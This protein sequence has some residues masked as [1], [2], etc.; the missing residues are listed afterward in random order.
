M[1]L[2]KPYFL[3]HLA[4]ALLLPIVLLLPASA[5]AVDRT[6]IGPSGGD[7]NTASNWSGGVVPG[8]GD[9]AIISG[10][11]VTVNASPAQ[12][13]DSVQIG[14]SNL[15]VAAGATLNVANS[16]TLTSNVNF[17]GPGAI[18]FA[19]GA[20]LSISAG[21]V[22][23]LAGADFTLPAGPG[24]STS[25]SSG[26]INM[27]GDAAITSIV[28]PSGATFPLLDGGTIAS[29]TTGD[30]ARVVNDG[31][32][33]KSGAGTTVLN[34]RFRNTGTVSVAAGTLNV[35]SGPPD[36][37]SH[38]AGFTAAAGAELRL[39]GG[40]HHLGSGA[41][42][43]GQGT[44]T[45]AGG[46]IEAGA[47]IPVERMRFGGAIAFGAGSSISVA[48]SLALVGGANAQ[49]N[50]QGAVGFAAG[51]TLSTEPGFGQL[52]LLGGVDFTL[53][54]GNGTSWTAGSIQLAGHAEITSLVVPAGATFALLDGGFIGSNTT[55]DTARIVNNG[56]VVKSGAG[57]TVVNPQFF[58]SGLVDVQAGTMG[59][60][61][62][63]PPFT[64]TSGETDV[65]SGAFLEMNATLDGGTLR[66]RGGV[67]HVTNDGGT[68][69]PG[70]AG[71]IGVLSV[72]GNYT[73]GSGGTLEVDI[74]GNTVGNGGATGYDRLAVGA[75]AN[76]AGTLA[77]VNNPS[78]APQQSD[79][80]TI[81]TRASGSGT[82][83]T[84]TG[85]VTSSGTYGATYTPTEVNLSLISEPPTVTINQAAGQADPTSSSP[86]LFDVVFSEPVT[87]FT[88]SDVSFAGSTVGGSLAAS[89]SGSGA[90]YTVSVTGMSGSGTVVASI[91]AGAA[92]DSAGN[93]SSASTSTDNSVTFVPD[94]AP[95]VTINQASG[96]ADPTS[97]SPILFDV[98]FSEP[99][100]GFTGGDVSFAGSTVGGSLTAS[101]SGSGASYQ[102][103]VSGM[104]SSGDVV[105][106]IPAG[107][108]SDAGGNGN[109][110]STSTDNRV[111]FV[112]QPPPSG[113]SCN[114]VAATI[115]V[116]A[117]GRIVGGPDNGKPYRGKLNGTPAADVMAG[118]AGRDEFAARGGNDRLCGREGNDEL[119]G[120]G[121]HDTL[122]G[123]GGND[124]LDAGGGNDTLTGGL[125]ADKFMGGTGRDTATDFTPAQGDTKT[126]VE[127]WV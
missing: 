85:A 32:I 117:D 77:I 26:V 103:S 66:G 100:T 60:S 5:Y 21:N 57:K 52:Q 40:A 102:V 8:P 87:G 30:T 115:Y 2:R 81:L 105:A 125:G 88:G 107:A 108:A 20:A 69:A 95:S 44:V 82:F 123:E 22:G 41:S 55:A 59:G 43:A 68:V 24:S 96:Q 56:T 114:G 3:M 73:Q 38:T 99:V 34:P 65:A 92:T 63:P 36:G 33:T 111:A 39:L 91:P 17:F 47:A 31:T 9:T 37:Q 76:L 11:D 97:S 58:N 46:A 42:F 110:A 94:A 7:W 64:Q 4:I 48:N 101:V 126:G 10:K 84:L 74:N 62:G 93:P 116:G 120:G 50:G 104:T 79:V 118:T 78:F 80:F 67:S 49:F 54:P 90:N 70:A 15:T 122:F 106:S 61:A 53:P 112:Q 29:N 83:D 19:S 89:V 16:M 14:G 113:P 1:N 51:A 6:F 13:P 75:A 18:D 23:F 45:Y 127:V 121:G 71:E 35:G 124:E 12:S 109:T 72:A 98:L 119:E 86:I 25:W 27:A 28:V